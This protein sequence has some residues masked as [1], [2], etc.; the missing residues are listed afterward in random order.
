MGSIEV[1]NNNIVKSTT[2]F[3][4]IS[5]GMTGKIQVVCRFEADSSTPF[6]R[7]LTSGMISKGKEVSSSNLKGICWSL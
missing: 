3:L 6:K 4:L 7:E 2:E 5:S 1:K